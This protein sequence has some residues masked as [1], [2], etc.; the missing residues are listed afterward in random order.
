[1]QTKRLTSK[2]LSRILARKRLL[3]EHMQGVATTTHVD[4]YDFD[5]D[6]EQLRSSSPQKSAVL[7]LALA[8]GVPPTGALALGSDFVWD[9]KATGGSGF[10]SF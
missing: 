3:Q 10:T 2:S 4:A 7:G 9:A 5:P 1:M 8:T 6:D